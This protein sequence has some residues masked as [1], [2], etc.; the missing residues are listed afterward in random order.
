[1]HKTWGLFF[2][3]DLGLPGSSC[4]SSFEASRLLKLSLPFFGASG[5][6]VGEPHVLCTGTQQSQDFREGL[7]VDSDSPVKRHAGSLKLPKPL[8]FKA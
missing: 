6:V 2:R 3:L 5:V 1:M 4:V 8:C 7:V